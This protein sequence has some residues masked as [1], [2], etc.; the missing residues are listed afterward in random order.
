MKKLLIVLTFLISVSLLAI[1]SSDGAAL[2]KRCKSCHGADGSKVPLKVES[3]VIKGQSKEEL[4]KKLE[5]YKAK[6]YGGAKKRT[7]EGQAKRLSSA[8]I[9]ALADHIS[10]F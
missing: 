8:D 2:Y 7:M 5:G 10:K 1:A 9:K 4:I 6:T 3:G